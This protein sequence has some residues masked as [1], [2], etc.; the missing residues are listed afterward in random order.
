MEINF[1]GIVGPT[2]NYSGLSY[3][4]LASQNHQFQESNPKTAALQGL[5]KMYFLAKLGLKQGVLPPHERPHIPS[6]RSLGFCGSDA[7]VLAQA[8]LEFPEALSMFGSAAAMWAANSATVT[9]SC[10]TYD[11]RVHFT[12]ANLSSYPHRSIESPVTAKILK[13]IF[14]EGAFFSHHSPLIGGDIFSDE[15]AANHTR[16]CRDYNAPGLHLFTFGRYAL[17]QNNALPVRFPARQTYEASQAISRLHQIDPKKVIFLQQHPNA[18]DAGAFHNDVLAVGN[19]QLFLYHEEAF[20]KSHQVID[21]IK[22]KGVE[23]DIGDIRCVEVKSKDISL[24]SA[25]DTYLFN[26]Q[27]LSLPNGKTA[28]LMPLECRNHQG[29]FQYT[30]EVLTRVVDHIYYIDVH[31]SMQNGGGPACLR[32]RVVLNEEELA[33]VHPA[34]F[35]DDVLYLKLKSWIHKHYRDRLVPDDLADP[36]LLKETRA[37]LEELTNILHLEPIY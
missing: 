4:N 15:G 23:L 3:G 35:L 34:I 30:Q 33:A 24:K 31:Q 19:K 5:E 18:I 10:D 2:H 26:S 28:L 13:N 8:R 22:K 11:S 16:L 29:I 17:Q 9:P 12:P 21:E 36:L 1:D 7:E 14:K 25:I 27:I 20:L 37:A 32:L 6:L